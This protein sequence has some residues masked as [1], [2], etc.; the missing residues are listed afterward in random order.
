MKRPDVNRP[1][2]FAHRGACRV[3]PE[4]TLP[5]FEAAVGLGAD[6]VELDVQYSSDGELM[7][8]HNPSLEATTDGAGRLTSHTSEELRALDAG[9]FFGPEFAGTRIPTL[10][11]VLDLLNGK[12]LVNVELKALDQTTSGIGADVVKSVRARD[13]QDQVVISSFNPMALRRA[14]GAG[15]E[16]ECALLLAPDL[17]GWLRSGMARRYSRA[18]ALHPEAPMVDEAYMARARKEGLPVRA[19]TVNDEPEMRRLAALGVDAIITDV[20]DV[21]ARVLG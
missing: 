21:L 19:W 18:N 8:F 3:A 15:P 11:E 13:M 4:N 7:V 14:R 17:P 12:L 6:G 16:I 2:I 10:D 5:A 20:P 9:S 1:L